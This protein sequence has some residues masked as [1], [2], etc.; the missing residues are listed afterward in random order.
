MSAVILSF[1]WLLYPIAW[2]LADG[3]S[4]IYPDSE[5]IFYGVLDIL[6]KPVF[7]IIHL[8]S[9]RNCDL[10]RLQLQSG[11]YT[12]SAAAITTHDMEKHPR[13]T[14]NTGMIANDPVAPAGHDNMATHGK[15]GFFQRKGK[16][17]AH[18]VAAD[19]PADA[20]T[21]MPRTSEATMASR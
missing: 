5:M 18:P 2:G 11:K 4:V 14:Q 15:K 1:L 16:F 21:T 8:V 19:H 17:D 6:A 9:L 7:L 12:T 20:N 10:T 13:T 3:G